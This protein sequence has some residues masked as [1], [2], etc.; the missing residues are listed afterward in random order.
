MPVLEDSV[1]GI[2]RFNSC[3]GLTDSHLTFEPGSLRPLL[4]LFPLTKWAVAVS[5]WPLEVLIRGCP[6]FFFACAILD[7]DAPKV[8]GYR[9]LQWL[10]TCMQWLG[11]C[12]NIHSGFTFAS[13]P[14]KNPFGGPQESELSSTPL[15]SSYQSLPALNR[16]KPKWASAKPEMRTYMCSRC[17]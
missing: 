5:N 15:V 8:T 6:F 14:E 7:P 9:S 17:E 11:M 13:R 1:G 2:H 3:L 4:L 16:A 10:Y 12:H